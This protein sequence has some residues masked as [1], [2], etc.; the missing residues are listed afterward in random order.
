MHVFDE[1]TMSVTRHALP[2]APTG[3]IGDGTQDAI[4]ERIT[5]L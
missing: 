2:Y 1:R 5:T 3:R 4:R